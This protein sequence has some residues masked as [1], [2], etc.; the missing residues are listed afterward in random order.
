M[1]S[2]NDPLSDR[3]LF[4]LRAA[5]PIEEVIGEHVQLTPGDD[6]TL[7]GICPFHE[8]ASPSFNVTPD[9]GSWFCFGCSTRGDVIRFVEKYNRITYAEAA[10]VLQKR[11]TKPTPRQIDE[12]AKQVNGHLTL[13][14]GRLP[15]C[16]YLVRHLNQCTSEVVDP[17]GEI[18]LCAQHLA[19]ALELIK[20][21]MK[22][23]GITK[24]PKA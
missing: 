6:G 22:T 7:K 16:R 8:E 4:L 15:R 19:R 11:L 17:D 23:T 20:R 21:G 3:E 5:S 10:I 14:T 18:L 9:R 1:T 2:V 24:A 13:A 12:L